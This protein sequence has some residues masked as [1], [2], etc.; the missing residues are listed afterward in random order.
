MDKARGLANFYTQMA[1][2][3]LLRLPQSKARDA[4]SRLTYVVIM[5]KK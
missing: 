4:M 1:A 2:E 5:R 3:A